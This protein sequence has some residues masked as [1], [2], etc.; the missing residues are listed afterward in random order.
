[1]KMVD[2]KELMMSSVFLQNINGESFSI[3]QEDELRESMS[4]SC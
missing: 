1:M 3:R 2:K 4:I